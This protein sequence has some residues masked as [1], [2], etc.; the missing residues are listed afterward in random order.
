[1]PLESSLTCAMSY[2]QT[3][4]YLFRDLSKRKKKAYKTELKTKI[5]DLCFYIE[6]AGLLSTPIK[7]WFDIL[8]NKFK[9]KKD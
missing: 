2:K 8:L 3:S 7:I 5:N 9:I 6:N 4:S 1:M